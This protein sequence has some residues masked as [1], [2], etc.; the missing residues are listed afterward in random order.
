MEWILALVSLVG[1]WALSRG[2]RWGWLLSTLA[3][4]GYAGLFWQAGLS[5][6]AG[7]NLLYAAT[8]LWGWRG[9]SV[10]H[11]RPRATLW[12]LAVVP[13]AL[14]LQHYT[15]TADAWVTAL[16]LMAQFLTSAKVG[17]VW[18]IWVVVDLVTAFFYAT[19]H[20]WGTMVLYLVLTAVAESAHR[21][22]QGRPA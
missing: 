6:Q 19:L 5:G 14:A 11:S 22:W 3:S 16:A 4:L 8:Q 9:E 20:W 15:G 18:R 17:Q 1:L 12:M 7:L 10:F 13:L 21:V 2:R